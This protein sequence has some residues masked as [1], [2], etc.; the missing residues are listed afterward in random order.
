MAFIEKEVGGNRRIC[1]SM[2]DPS[3]PQVRQELYDGRLSQARQRKNIHTRTSDPGQRLTPSLQSELISCV[4][5]D[6][7]LQ[8]GSDLFTVLS[9][10]KCD[11][12]S[13]QTKC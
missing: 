10:T 6:D 3:N 1:Q 13:R 7:M 4:T 5:G 8:I 12:H 9:E 11:A 2:S